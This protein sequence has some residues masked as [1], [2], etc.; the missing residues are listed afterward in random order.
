MTV[1]V[2]REN[3]THRICTVE[4]DD[5]LESHERLHQDTDLGYQMSKYRV[6]EATGDSGFEMKYD[7]NLYDKDRERS[8]DT[9]YSESEREEYR[10]RAEK[11]ER[12]YNFR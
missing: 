1:R 7:V 4:S 8:N 9:R 12:R 5:R 10:D 11:T 6:S 3:E 2:V